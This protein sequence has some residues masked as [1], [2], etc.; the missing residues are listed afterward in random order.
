M[1]GHRLSLEG[2]VK[3]HEMFS[4]LK[5]N[6]LNGINSIHQAL[7]AADASQLDNAVLSAYG[8]VRTLVP[9]GVSSTL[10][11]NDRQSFIPSGQPESSGTVSAKPMYTGPVNCVDSNPDMLQNEIDECEDDGGTY[12]LDNCTCDGG[13]GGDGGGGGGAPEVTVIAWLNAGAISLPTGA[14]SILQAALQNSTAAQAALCAAE[15]GDWVTGNRGAVVTPADAAY[16]TAWLAKNSGNIP[17]PATIVPNTIL[18]GGNFRLFSD[19]L[20]YTYQVGST[21]D[22]CNTGKITGWYPSLPGEAS[23]Y[24]GMGTSPSGLPY[25]LTEGRIGD[26]GQI[27]NATLNQTSTPW[28]WNAIESDINETPSV[29]SHAM[30]PTYSVYVNGTLT[31]TYPQSSVSTFAAENDTYELTPSQLP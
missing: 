1:G 27:V 6:T 4:D 26:V 14:N 28:I 25:L 17:P 19:T 31:N 21:P 24:N 11:E 20:S 18:L 30:F 15:V 3:I 22:P 10:F 23:P 5:L 7:E 13:S 12:D 2:R 16:G 29:V 9:D 8:T